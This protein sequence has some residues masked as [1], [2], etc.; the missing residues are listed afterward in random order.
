LA[1][2]TCVVLGFTPAAANNAGLLVDIRLALPNSVIAGER[3]YVPVRAEF[4]N[5]HE[6]GSEEEEVEFQLKWN[7]EDEREGGDTDALV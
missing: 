6:R 2:P 7:L 3:I 5:E 4:S 1:T